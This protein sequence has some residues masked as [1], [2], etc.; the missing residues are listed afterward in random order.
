MRGLRAGQVSQRT[1]TGIAAWR[2]PVPFAGPRRYGRCETTPATVAYLS[3]SPPTGRVRPWAGDC[4]R[5]LDATSHVRFE[6]PD[7]VGSTVSVAVAWAKHM[8]GGAETVDLT[9]VYRPGK[10]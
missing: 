1:R 10:L 8:T 6:P 9:A 7:W 5:R 2:G 3:T 4:V